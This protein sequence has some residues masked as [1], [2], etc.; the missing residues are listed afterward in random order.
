MYA[1]CGAGGDR[2]LVSCRTWLFLT[3]VYSL[4]VIVRWFVLGFFFILWLFF[5]MAEMSE[6]ILGPMV[7]GLI[8]FFSANRVHLVRCFW[9]VFWFGVLVIDRLI[10]MVV[11][12]LSI[13]E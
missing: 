9:L 11:Y 8:F 6:V 2:Y 4:S 1:F 12:S 3:G 7:L 5:L 13:V 10:F